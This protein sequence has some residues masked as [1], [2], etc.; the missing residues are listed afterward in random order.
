M[1]DS[2]QRGERDRGVLVDQL[3]DV[4]REE[5]SSQQGQQSRGCWP[6]WAGWWRKAQL[7]GAN[8]V[9]CQGC[10]SWQ[11][12]DQPG[13]ESSFWPSAHVWRGK[14]RRQQFPTWQVLGN[15]KMMVPVF[16][17][18]V[19]CIGVFLGGLGLLEGVFEYLCSDGS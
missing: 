19:V 10:S 4:E 11:C 7:A 18:Q 14:F 15:R 5:D 9:S 8:V 1:A 3:T 16:L 13:A 2:P 12:W 6:K 17:C